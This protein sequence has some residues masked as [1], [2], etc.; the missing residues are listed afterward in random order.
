MTIC[1]FGDLGFGRLGFLLLQVVN[2]VGNKVF[3]SLF[4][5]F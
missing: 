2:K 3:I 5:G 4:I 1:G